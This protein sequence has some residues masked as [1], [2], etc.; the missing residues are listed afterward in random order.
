MPTS[1][2][3]SSSPLTLT[4]T[5]FSFQSRLGA[6]WSLCSTSSNLTST[7]AWGWGG[8]P[9]LPVSFGASL[10]PHPGNAHP[11]HSQHSSYTPRVWR[12]IC[13]LLTFQR[14]HTLLL[15]C[16]C[17]FLF[18]CHLVTTTTQGLPTDILVSYHLFYPRSCHQ[19]THF[20]IHVDN[21]SSALAFTLLHPLQSPVTSLTLESPSIVSPEIFALLSDYYLLS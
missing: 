7:L 9:S 6:L 1:S 5:V 12:E 20:H 11:S 14:Y 3:L 21:T 8:I 13:V 17:L 19:L 15:S 16:K 18:L 10:Q 4:L 2:L